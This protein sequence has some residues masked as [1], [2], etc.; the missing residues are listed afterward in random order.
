MFAQFLLTLSKPPAAIVDP[1]SVVIKEFIDKRINIG[2]IRSRDANFNPQP[3]I[4]NK[5]NR[6][7][8]FL[9]GNYSTS[10]RP[11]NFEL[12]YIFEDGDWKLVFIRVDTK[13]R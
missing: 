8:L 12:E 11:V 7:V 13:R 6:K 4:D 9:K 3:Y 2:N 1:R 5:Y 10:P